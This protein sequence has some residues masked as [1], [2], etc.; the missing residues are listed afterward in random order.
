M[1][2]TSAAVL[3]DLCG[4]ATKP[5]RYGQPV[6]RCPV[7]GRWK[8]ALVLDGGGWFACWACRRGQAT[9]ERE[10]EY[11]RQRASLEEPA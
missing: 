1:T 9:E 5:G 7:C 4:I 10:R 2:T 11:E 3:F 8:A 6:L